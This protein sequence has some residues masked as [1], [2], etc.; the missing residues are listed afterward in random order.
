MEKLK[1]NQAIPDKEK[2]S[3]IRKAIR[4]VRKGNYTF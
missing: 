3:L 2:I 1:V 4:K